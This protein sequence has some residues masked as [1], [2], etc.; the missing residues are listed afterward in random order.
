[1][2]DVEVEKLKVEKTINGI[3]D[4]LEDQTTLFGVSLLNIDSP[5]Q[6]KEALDKYGLKLESTK[7]AELAKYRGIELIDAVL[8]Y[9][10]YAKLISTYSESLIEKIKEKT[11]RLHTEFRQ[12]VATGRMSSSKPNLQ[13]IPKKQ[14]YRSCFIAND[15][16]RL[17]TA[18]MHGAELRIL[19]NLSKE[20]MF[21][22]AYAHGID[23]HTKAASEVYEVPMDKVDEDMRD[24]IKAIQFGII[25][26]M[27]KFG[28]SRRL[29]ISE[30]KADALIN[31]YFRKFPIVK[32]YLDKAGKDGV[33]KRY[34]RT[35]SG[36][37]RFYRLPDYSDPSFKKIKSGIERQA[38]NAG[39]QGANADTIKQAMVYLVDRLGESG[40]DA[41]L[42]STVHD[43]VIVESRKEQV[44]EVSSIITRSIIDGFG[45]YFHL[46]PM[47]TDALVG[48]CWLKGSCKSKDSNG[49]KCGGM[50]M[51]SV[52]TNDKYGSKIV[53]KKC[54]EEI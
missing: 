39:I 50:E 22:D 19:G 5:I 33:Y 6:L 44:E 40:L 46:I 54:G 31:N 51:V 45:H 11:G 43:E 32:S 23:L 37:K 2:G 29:S 47:E 24:S 27:S 13:N 28:L 41:K 16:Y 25:Y 1:M 17:I 21:I 42:I 14:M 4:P 38:K 53:C 52:P 18:D 35:I 10:K 26:G 36:R 48:P 15:G 8:E 3:M 30:S 12:M 20:P 49:K 9:R 34:S 7:D